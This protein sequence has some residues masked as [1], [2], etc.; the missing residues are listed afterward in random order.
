MNPF[1]GPRKTIWDFARWESQNTGKGK[2][3]N[4]P[5]SRP[6]WV[7]E[8]IDG[9][10]DVNVGSEHKCVYGWLGRKAGYQ[11][12]K[13]RRSLCSR[14]LQSAGETPSQTPVDGR[15]KD[16]LGERTIGPIS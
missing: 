3:H 2:C 7:L 6:S 14:R 13:Q 11:E 10:F 12:P 5:K 15:E 9:E 4:F 8:N 1:S 16:R